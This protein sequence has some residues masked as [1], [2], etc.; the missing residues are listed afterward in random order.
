MM[1]IATQT[2][3]EPEDAQE[4]ETFQPLTSQE[5]QLLRQ[6]LPL[7]S[8][9]RVVAAQVLVGVVVALLAG[10]M[11][12]KWNV[13]WS[14][15]YGALAVTMPAALFARGMTSPV[16]SASVGASVTGF[17]L[18][19]IMKIGLTLAMLMAAPKVVPQV[20]WPAMLVG[21]VLTMKVYWMV[22][23]A[24]SLFYPKVNFKSEQKNV[25]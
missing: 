14:A 19:E 12:S 23:G 25:S 17:L 20:S 18:W 24:S 6:K 10:L 7:L 16:T 11:T 9:W 21:L 3:T 13:A 4:S 8:V 22:L 15:G 1:T 2:Q 5:A